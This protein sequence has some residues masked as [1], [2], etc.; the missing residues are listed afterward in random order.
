MSERLPEPVQLG[1]HY[2]SVIYALLMQADT[3]ADDPVWF[4]PTGE[5]TVLGFPLPSWQRG[6][7]WG[8]RQQVS[9]IESVWRGIPLGTYTYNSMVHENPKFRGLLIDGLQ[10]LTAISDYTLDAFPVFSLYYSELTRVEKRRFGMT[11]FCSYEYNSANESELRAYYNLMNF[12]GTA[13][14]EKDR[15]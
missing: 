8:S 3:T 10:R 13:H 4:N 2:D 1:S 5:R 6:S 9:F 14:T 7:V 15:A 12:G 11:K